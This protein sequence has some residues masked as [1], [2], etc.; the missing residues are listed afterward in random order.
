MGTRH[1]F[2]RWLALA[3]TV[4][5]CFSM[6]HAAAAAPEYRVTI[7]GPPDSRAM[8]I[9]QD[10]VVVGLYPG[11]TD[12]THAFKSRSRGWVGLDAP[13]VT[14]GAVSINDRGEVL[15]YWRAADGTWHGVVWHRGG[16]N[17]LG[18][19][20][21]TT[22]TVY[23]AINNAGYTVARA[24]KNEDY[25]SYLRAPNGNFQDLGSLGTGEF[26]TNATALNN[27]N[28][29][30][31][32]SS[33]FSLPEIPFN[34]FLWTRGVLRD[35]GNFGSAPNEG[36]DINDR[37][38]VTGYLAVNAGG[39]HDRVAFIWSNGRLQDIDGRPRTGQIYSQGQ[40]LNNLGHAVGD[41]DHLSGW[42]YRG[43]RMQSLNTLID[44]ALGWNIQLPRD[45]N[46][47]GQIAATGVHNG[48][49]YAVRLDLIRP[50]LETPPVDEVALPN[51]SLSP[52]QAAAEAKLDAEA[53][54]REVVHPIQQ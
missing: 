11:S 4:L 41:S 21:G 15:G 33:Q 10:G 2:R 53:Q 47:A 14:S 35:L 24:Y 7:V 31:G 19:V 25:R 29:V 5:L 50:H 43:K 37:G 46:D 32:G 49:Y 23:V 22:S 42:V 44:P 9:N 1:F 52:E 16:R 28:Q 38:Q 8:A 51:I 26:I 48:Q 39:A 17:E 45:I 6:F 18:F 12:A 13:G 30:T 36:N 34:A 20:P 27:R 3:F 40:G 54:A